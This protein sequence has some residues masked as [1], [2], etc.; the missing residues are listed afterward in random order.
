MNKRIGIKRI[1]A[2]FA[3][4]LAAAAMLLIATPAAA[5]QGVINL[6]ETV[7]KG[8]IQ[9]PE[10]FYILQHANLRYEAL[11]PKP[12][13]IPELLKTVREDPF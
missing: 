2:A 10:A 3:S 1:T 6:D 9:K 7:I 12:T 8:R 4:I 11:D 13:F 5:Q